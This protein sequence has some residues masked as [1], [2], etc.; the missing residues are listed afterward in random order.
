M[1]KGAKLTIC[2]FRSIQGK[3]KYLYILIILILF[4]QHG[5]KKLL[6]FQKVGGY[7]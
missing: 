3:V 7:L 2:Q 5:M 6:Y 4:L 1:A